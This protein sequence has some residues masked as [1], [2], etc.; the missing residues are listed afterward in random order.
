M[1]FQERRTRP[2]LGV[3][4]S[5]PRTVVTRTFS[6][7]YGLAGSGWL[8]NR[9]EELAGYTLKVAAVRREPDSP[10]AVCGA[11]DRST[12]TDGGVDQVGPRVPVFALSSWVSRA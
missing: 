2:M 8:W 1:E 7:A 4:E 3:L 6:K 10:E 11:R 12:S 5:R 9:L